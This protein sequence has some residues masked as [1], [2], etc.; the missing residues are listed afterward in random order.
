MQM[1]LIF[2][3]DGGR[4]FGLKKVYSGRNR[5]KKNQLCLL[6][7]QNIQSWPAVAGGTKVN[8]YICIAKKT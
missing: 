2:P 7:S 8:R 3:A 6:E 1:I 4:D 5:P